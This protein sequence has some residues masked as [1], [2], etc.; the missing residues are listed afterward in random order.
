MTISARPLHPLFAAELT[1]ADLAA[2]IDAATR[3]AI[4][5]AMDENAVVVLPGQR[6]DDDRQIAFASLNM[7]RK[8]MVQSVNQNLS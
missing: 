7:S 1:G 5:R 3:D 4:E 8:S 6:L 2:G